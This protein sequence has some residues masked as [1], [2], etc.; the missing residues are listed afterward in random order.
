MRRLFVILGAFIAL[1][2]VA[3][4]GA[5][6]GSITAAQLKSGFRKG[7]GETLLVNRQRSFAGHYT[8]FDLGA[9]TIYRQARYGTFTV[10]L[11]SGADVEAE[12]TDLLSDAHTGALGRPA[13]GNVYWESGRTPHG[14][15]YWLAK[16]RYGSNLVLHWIGSKPVKKT[17]ATFAKLHSTLL[18]IAKSQR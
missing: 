8:A 5:S 2:G 13:S 9:Q 17:D 10:Y 7:T 6:P 16:R 11:V 18:G 4:A 14:D 1:M 12:V 3:G 15:R